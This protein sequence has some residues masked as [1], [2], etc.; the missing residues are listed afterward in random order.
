MG[1]LYWPKILISLILLYISQ[2]PLEGINITANSIVFWKQNNMEGF[3][4]INSLTIHSAQFEAISDYECTDPNAPIMVRKNGLWGYLDRITGKE[5][6]PCIYNLARNDSEFINGYAI[7]ATEEQDSGNIHNYLFNSIG[8]Q[9]IFP[10]NIEPDS[11][12]YE[13]KCFVIFNTESGKRGIGKVVNNNYQ[14]LIDPMYNDIAVCSNIA[15]L[16]YV[17]FDNYLASNTY[18]ELLDI[19]DLANGNQYIT[20]MAFPSNNE[21]FTYIRL[22]TAEDQNIVLCLH[23]HD[24]VEIITQ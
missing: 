1:K 4:D 2:F 10:H 6:V 7:I 11:Q 20:K 16:F 13:N 23:G 15:L 17:D 21:E 18:N 9:I 3:V 19:I 5:I 24:I 14:V 8:E 12:V 22:C